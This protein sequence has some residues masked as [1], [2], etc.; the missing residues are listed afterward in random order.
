MN[1]VHKQRLTN[2]FWGTHG[3]ALRISLHKKRFNIEP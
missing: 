2:P 1:R 3:L